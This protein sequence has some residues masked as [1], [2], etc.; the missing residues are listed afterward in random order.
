MNC[1]FCAN[2]NNLLKISNERDNVSYFICDLCFLGVKKCFS[3]DEKLFYNPLFCVDCNIKKCNSYDNFKSSFNKLITYL[4]Q[5]E[6]INDDNFF[7]NK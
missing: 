3:C 7:I 5:I 1:K 2:N 4:Q 6:I